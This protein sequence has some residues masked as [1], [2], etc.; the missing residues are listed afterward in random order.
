[1]M[2]S[3]LFLDD[4]LSTIKKILSKKLVD[5]LIITILKEFLILSI[6][7]ERFLFRLFLNT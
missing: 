5:I 3:S 2:K 4:T 6:D 7:I 1:M